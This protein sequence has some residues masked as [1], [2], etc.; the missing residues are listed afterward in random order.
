MKLDHEREKCSNLMKLIVRY[1]V[2]RT[3]LCSI[4][5][6]KNQVQQV[7]FVQSWSIW[8]ISHLI[9]DSNSLCT[10]KLITA[11]PSFINKRQS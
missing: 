11:N 8:K 6:S 5:I 1:F 7:T 2:K 3:E 10:V 9:K 4:L